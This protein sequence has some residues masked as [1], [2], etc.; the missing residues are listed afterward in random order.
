MYRK[1]RFSISLMGGIVGI[2]AST[3]FALDE[4]NVLVVYNSASAEGQQIAEYYASIHP[5][6]SLLGIDNVPVQEDID[7]QVYLN[8]IRPQ[9]LAALNGSIDCIVTTKGMPL[10]I[11]NNN[12]GSH[13]IT[14]VYS[15][16]ESELTRIDTIDSASL[17]GNQ[18]MPMPSIPPAFTNPYVV[19]P[20]CGADGGFSYATYGTRLTARLDGFTVEDVIAGINNAF[21]VAYGDKFFVV[22]DDP[23]Y[24][25]DRMRQLADDVLAPSGVSYQYDDT[26]AFLNTAPGPVI[27]Y[28]SHGRYGGAPEGYILDEVNGLRFALAPGAIMQTWESFNAYS[29]EEGGNRL[30]QGLLAEWIARGGSGGVGT[31]EEPGATSSAVANEARIFELMLDGYSWA[32]AAWNATMQLSFVNT[33][34]GDPLMRWFDFLVPGDANGDGMVD[35][36]DL[37]I[38]LANWGANVAP[39]DALHGELSGDG[40]VGMIDMDLVLADFLY[41]VPSPPGAGAA[42][43]APEPA[44]VALLM[45][46]ALTLIRTKRRR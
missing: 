40:W 25:Y 44:T 38:V 20:Y 16:L 4:S 11:T 35:T 26:S 13:M 21:R 29:F 18:M 7:E 32:E 34:V 23:D 1:S 19:N 14:N 9:V 41:G 30:G 12:P 45:V 27:G 33:V 31:V 15:S 42:S 6:V 17:M 8:Q 39:G 43:P 3:V 5:G 36:D 10:R 28:V 46:G 2:L 24:T 37:D 22:D